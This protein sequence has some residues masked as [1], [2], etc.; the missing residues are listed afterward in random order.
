MTRIKLFHRALLTLAALC[1]AGTL[2][3]GFFDVKAS[4]TALRSA[5]WG[6][7]VATR[8]DT[9]LAFF[10]TCLGNTECRPELREQFIEED[11]SLR[12]LLLL[13]GFFLFLIGA[14]FVAPFANA[15]PAEKDPG[16]GNFA[17]DKDLKAYLKD[18]K[19]P[20]NPRRG[21]YGYTESGKQLKAPQKDRCTHLAIFAGTG[22]GKTTRVIKPSLIQD[23][24]DGTSVLMVD[25]KWPDPEGGYSDML[26]VFMAQGY[27]VQVFCPFEEHTM[28]LPLI[29]SLRSRADA[30]VLA[31]TIMP[32]AT[33][34]ETSEGV[35][36]Y[37]NQERELLKH[38]LWGEA[39][40]GRGSM[41]DVYDLLDG[42]P[43]A[44]RAWLSACEDP[45]I[46][47][48]MGTLL[49]L[50]PQTLVGLLQGLKGTLN[51]FTNEQLDT[52]TQAGRYGWQDLRPASL[53]D[54][55]SVLYVGIPQQMFLRGE[56]KLLLN[57]FFRRI[58]DEVLGLATE[59]GGTLERH[60]AV[61]I[62]E[63]AHVGRLEDAGS[64][65]GM[66]RSYNIA[67]TVAMQNRA[68][69]EL[70]YGTIGAR[71]MEGGN[72]Q[73]LITFPASLRGDDKEYVSKLLG[74]VTAEE[75]TESRSRQHIFEPYRT[76]VTRRR[77]A[78]P[79][80]SREEMDKWD[81]DYGVLVPHGAGPTKIAAPR[82]DQR[83]VGRAKNRFFAYRKTVGVGNSQALV[84]SILSRHR[85]EWRR[86][87]PPKSRV[88]AHTAAPEDTVDEPFRELA[89]ATQTTQTTPR[90]KGTAVEAPVKVVK[91][92]EPKPRKAS[93]TLEVEPEIPPVKVVEAPDETPPEAPKKTQETSR[94]APKAPKKPSRQAPTRAEGLHL[95]PSGELM[96]SFRAWID[97]LS[98]REVPLTVYRVR[99]GGRDRISKVLF[100]RLP[101]ALRHEH[102]AHWKGRNWLRI[103]RGKLGIINSGCTVLCPVQLDRFMA[104]PHA[105]VVEIGEGSER[106]VVKERTEG[107]E[108]SPL[109]A[110][111]KA[112][113]WKRDTATPAPEAN[114]APPQS[115]P[116]APSSTDDPEVQAALK[117]WIARNGWRLDGHPSYDLSREQIP[118]DAL[119]GRYL[120][121][122]L[123]VSETY[124]KN[125]EGFP[126]QAVARFPSVKQM[127]AGKTVALRAIPHELARRL[128]PLKKLTTDDAHLLEGH[129]SYMGEG[130]AIGSY[131][132]EEVQL[133][134]LK[135]EEV[136]GI[137]FEGSKAKVRKMGFERR[138]I[139]LIGV[140][141]HPPQ[142]LTATSS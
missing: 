30:D 10:F 8:V 23:A 1:F 4:V 141:L 28:R 119:L 22:G 132:W 110:S 139:R 74:E 44:I 122:M 51:I 43:K 120:P 127:V 25:P 117:A 140:R 111:M 70:V 60:L 64:W 121:E 13:G 42:G 96:H 65:F 15:K 66:M 138:S 39:Q 2:V 91:G 114:P 92:K 80:L 87:N 54:R 59:Q 12:S 7:Y 104:S 48:S 67:F 71:A 130:Q 35:Q 27:E 73:H 90:E 5:G 11:L 128:L 55:K 21:Y 31:S 6:T 101:G 33:L 109:V 47:S 129:P 94:K 20:N 61:Y 72:F 3:S 95:V 68:Q 89:E 46:V 63:F 136:T 112:N 57:L 14:A 83:R 142:T 81:P 29:G 134:K 77:V 108:G 82:I 118:D 40:A 78:R 99:E 24:V 41:G 116:K 50:P 37:R 45:R 36:F 86:E 113:G 84:Q 124:L 97:T 88:E 9:P 123:Y 98:W 53:T 125:L 17:T 115:S 105:R 137:S 93:V 106:V 69:L 38:L 16:G 62:D 133:Q 100:D 26:A 19:D 58:M 34:G 85:L 135:M 52:A 79:L 49:Q 32:R 76:T 102:L 103:H 18:G 107:G 56:G 75:V 131:Q 126:S